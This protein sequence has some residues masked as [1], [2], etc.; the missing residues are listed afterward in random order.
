MCEY[1]FDW[2]ADG[3]TIGT[4]GPHWGHCDG[5]GR[6]PSGDE[7]CR[8]YFGADAFGEPCPYCVPWDDPGDGAM[9]IDDYGVVVGFDRS[10]PCHVCRDEDGEIREQHQA[11]QCARCMA[12]AGLLNKWCDGSFGISNIAGQI[13]DHWHE[14]ELYRSYPFARLVALARRGWRTPGGRLVDPTE[15]AE[16]VQRS[17]ARVS[18]PA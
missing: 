12:A 6:Q 15:I 9:I 14:D 5:C 18:V 17:I 10:R 11:L 7:T 4:W 16:L 13:C 8:I 1:E 2:Y 3:D